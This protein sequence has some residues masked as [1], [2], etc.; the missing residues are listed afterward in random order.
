MCQKDRPEKMQGKAGAQGQVQGKHSGVGTA[1]LESTW[2]APHPH[3][4]TCSSSEMG[5]GDQ[6]ASGLRDL[7]FSHFS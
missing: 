7:T 1:A 2:G 5:K 4:T 3:T 6:L